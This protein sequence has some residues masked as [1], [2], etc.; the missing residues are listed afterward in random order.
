MKEFASEIRAAVRSGRLTEPFDA[1]A[2]KQACPGWAER[3]YHAFL[4]KHALGNPG[5][6]T[7][8]FVRVDIGR[9]RLRPGL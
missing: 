4:P 3:T 2:V 6:N 5:K 1:A 9:Y 7:E 8:L